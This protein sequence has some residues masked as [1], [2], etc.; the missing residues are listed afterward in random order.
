MTSVDEPARPEGRVRDAARTKAEI[1]DVAT[2]EFAR[3]GYDGARVDEIAARTRTTKRMI[4]YYFGGKEQLFTAALERA[5]EVIRQ[6]EQQLDVE[7]LEPVAAIRRLAEVTF[8]HHEAHPDFIRLVSIENMHG[9]VHIAGS[10]KLGRIA[11]PAL[12]VIRRILAAGRESGL[13]KADVDAVD[14]HA[15]ISSFCFFRVA[16]RHT[17]GTLFGR[18]L[19]DPVRRERLRAMLGDMVIAYLTADRAETGAPGYGE[20]G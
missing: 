7:H 1:L 3:A 18:D 20:A 13:F 2:Q 15:V 9:A 17:F 4:Y 5:Y 14:L 12:E 19:V 10:E 11:S 6:A 8:D 16:N